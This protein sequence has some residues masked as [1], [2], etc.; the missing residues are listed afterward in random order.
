MP[1]IR[2]S[3]EPP[4]A[5]VHSTP[6]ALRVAERYEWIPMTGLAAVALLLWLVAAMDR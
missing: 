2:M 1:I 5:A 3:Q 4:T 6:A